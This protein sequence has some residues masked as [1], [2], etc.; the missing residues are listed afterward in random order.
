MKN[1]GFTL[2]EVLLVIGIIVLL[3]GAIIVAINPGRQLARTRDTQ[4]I[5]D[6]AQYISAIRQNETENGRF[7]CNTTNP[8]NT[9]PSTIAT[10]ST[11]TATGGYTNLSCLI[12]N[13]FAGS[14]PE[15]PLDNDASGT[16]YTIQY[17]PITRRITVCA[18]LMEVNTNQCRTQ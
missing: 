5:N 11:N 4:R 9:L 18:P 10:I 13:Y 1:K 15:D 3:A 14:L 2:I 8:A 12:G 17:D 16:G 7:T 6:I